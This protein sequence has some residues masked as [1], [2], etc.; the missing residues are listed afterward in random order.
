MG[1]DLASDEVV[2]MK[3][4]QVLRTILLT[5]VGTCMSNESVCEL[6]QSCFRLSYEMRLS[7]LLRKS[8]E[9]TLMDMVHLLFSRLGSLTDESAATASPFKRTLK[10]TASQLSENDPRGSVTSLDPSAAAAPPVSP[11]PSSAAAEMEAQAA[12]GRTASPASPDIVLGVG[13]DLTT[14]R[15]EKEDK[16]TSMYNNRGV[17][18]TPREVGLQVLLNHFIQVAHRIFLIRRT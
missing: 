17:R 8:A 12:D 1:T 11:A 7:E 14:P 2:L 13:V 5:P 18:F 10:R 9:Q 4:L 16:R 6:M 3:I 15:E